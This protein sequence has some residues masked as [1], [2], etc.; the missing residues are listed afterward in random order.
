MCRSY[1]RLHDLDARPSLAV[2]RCRRA[3]ARA[4]GAFITAFVSAVQVP[5]V[6]SGAATQSTSMTAAT[7]TAELPGTI[8][9]CDPVGG[10]V[11]IAS[12]QVLSLVL[13]TVTQST[14][15]GPL[16]LASSAVVQAEV[17]NLSPLTVQYDLRKGAKWVTGNPINYRDFVTTWHIGAHGNG[18]SAAS[19]RRIKKV[20]QGNS[21]HVVQVTFSRPTSSWQGLFS[22]LLPRGI[23]ER[24]L[25]RCTTPNAQVNL[26][27]GPY[28][29]AASSTSG[30]ILVRNPRWWGRQPPFVWI[31]VK[32]ESPT[33][34]EQAIS[35]VPTGSLAFIERS[36]VSSQTLAALVSN[37][38]VSSQVDSSNRL[39]SMDF[40]LRRG[41]TS[42]LKVRLALEHL[43]DRE[44]LVSTTA[45]LVNPHV[46]VASSHLISQGQPGYGG[47]TGVPLSQETTTTQ[48]PASAPST[49]LSGLMIA[50]KDL[51]ASGWRRNGSRWI[52][53]HGRALS[54]RLA[55]PGND[56]WAISATASLA[57][58]LRSHGIV[59]RIVEASTSTKVTSMLRTGAVSLGV[60]S[61]PTDPFI[62]HAAQWFNVPPTGPASSLWAGYKD[63]QVARLANTADQMLNAS[64]A[65]QLYEAMDRRLWATM[66]SLP[67]YTEPFVTAWS[68]TIGGVIDNPYPPGT[69]AEAPTWVVNSDA[70]VQTLPP[71]DH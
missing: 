41:P 63:T 45:A 70:T 17:V 25:D 53:R 6:S 26:S 56:P 51:E 66:P 5:S 65:Q 16:G 48:Q 39:L 47:A 58:Q 62:A 37:P 30:V 21:R 44:R 67:L 13:P 1:L 34:A 10:T 40:S 61:R 18:P 55:V 60:L 9:G 7:L 14:P 46:G 50:R 24:A 31:D 2:N 28:V 27:A 3:R 8:S 11:S 38:F 69:L 15:A 49:S 35:N 12:M 4:F 64:T 33:N 42:H 19:Y 54:M 20:T 29:I 32:A 22:P 23:T 59:V 52:D 68:S 43:I 57:Q 71:P 36:W